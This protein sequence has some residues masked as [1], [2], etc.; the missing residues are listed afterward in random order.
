[1]HELCMNSCPCLASSS[2]PSKVNHKFANKLKEEK[3]TLHSCLVVYLVGF[4][5]YFMTQ[6]WCVCSRDFLCIRWSPARL[7]YE[8]TCV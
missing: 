3:H 8:S 7:F 4:P 6:T 1:M 5:S 2:N